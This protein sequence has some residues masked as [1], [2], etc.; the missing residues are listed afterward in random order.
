M[1]DRDPA[2]F[3]GVVYDAHGYH[4][5]GD[6][7]KPGLKWKPSVDSCKTCCR[8]PVLLAPLVQAKLPM[9]IGEYSLNTGLPGRSSSFES[10]LNNQLSLWANTPGVIGSFFWNHRVSRAPGKYYHEMSLLDLMSPQGPLQPLPRQKF[11]LCPKEDLSLCP[12]FEIQTV[13]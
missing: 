1:L 8:D 2:S 11:K 4:S 12:T 9:V 7:N 6:D 10:Y 13:R 3:T 5:Y